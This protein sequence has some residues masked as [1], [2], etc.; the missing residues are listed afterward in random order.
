MLVEYG[1]EAEDDV[2]G[3]K[4]FREFSAILVASSRLKKSCEMSSREQN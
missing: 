3:D 2:E 4:G 1:L